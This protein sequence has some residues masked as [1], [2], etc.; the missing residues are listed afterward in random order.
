MLGAAG[1]F[2]CKG[3]RSVSYK[4]CPSCGAEYRAK[5]NICADCQVALSPEP[6]S[7]AKLHDEVTGAV[8]YSAHSLAPVFVSGRRSDAEMARGFLETQGVQAEVWSAGLSPADADFGA[9]RVMVPEDQVEEARTLLASVETE[10]IFDEGSFDQVDSYDDTAEP[11]DDDT[12][13]LDS[14]L[15][16]LRQRWAVLAFALAILLIVLFIEAPG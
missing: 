4:Y 13:R 14:A 2:V 6:S 9:S 16:F 5:F 11:F 8:E 7:A 15:D 3:K 10:P 12:D 1:Q